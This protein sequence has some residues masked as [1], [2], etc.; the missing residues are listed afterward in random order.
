MTTTL[1]I[2]FQQSN[3][4]LT[5]TLLIFF[6]QSNNDGGRITTSFCLVTKSSATIFVR[7]VNRSEILISYFFNLFLNFC[8]IFN[9]ISATAKYTFY[10][11]SLFFTAHRCYET[12]INI[13]NQNRPR[14]KFSALQRAIKYNTFLLS[15][16]AP[17]HCSAFLTM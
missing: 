5:T 17:L 15:P 3:K 7:N 16:S 6:Q 8:T 12:E 1:L 9:A 10:F 14:Y 11:Q 2:F 4:T 13:E